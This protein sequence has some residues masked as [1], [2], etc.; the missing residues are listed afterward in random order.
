MQVPPY[1]SLA[2]SPS[3]RGTCLDEP[4]NTELSAPLL[5]PEPTTLP[6]YAGVIPA[7]SSQLFDLLRTKWLRQLIRPLAYDSL[8]ELYHQESMAMA[9]YTPFY[10]HALLAC[11]AAEYP[12]DDANGSAREEFS[13]LSRKH[14]ICSITG[15]REALRT[16][17]SNIHR[18]GIIRTVLILC[19]FE[20]A[21]PWPSSGVGAHLSGLAQ[22]IQS[23][24]A[25][26]T[27]DCPVST[28]GVAQRRIVLEGFVFHAATSVPFQPLSDQQ[29]NL[30]WTMR[31]AQTKLES[32]FSEGSAVKPDSPVLGVEPKLFVLVRELSLMHREY[33]QSHADCNNPRLQRGQTLSAMQ[34]QLSV[35]RRLYSTAPCRSPNYLA[36]RTQTLSSGYADASGNNPLL[37]GP[38]LY[39]TA[40]EI[41]LSDILGN[42][43]A[44]N[45]FV[46][47]LS[48]PGLVLEGVELVRQLDP[49][50]DYYAEY[51]GWPIYVLAKFVS[52]EQDRKCLLS[53]VNAFWQETRSGTMARL[54]DIL[55]NGDRIST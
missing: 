53:Q 15:L 18:E 26:G 44:Q 16:A 10:M 45:H 27:L 36:P 2:V 14:Y 34:E 9:M 28:V 54:A 38:L 48:I 33:E 12:V 42:A 46:S 24:S 4:S 52:R 7:A 22:L 47:A 43:T 23:E 1:N 20:R 35:Y 6:L 30:D 50:K 29:S 32:M 31:F 37:I 21:K 5:Y 40:A 11:C 19:I 55:G 39:I 3:A 17:E 13:R 8:I 41:L 51:Y 49:T 25:W